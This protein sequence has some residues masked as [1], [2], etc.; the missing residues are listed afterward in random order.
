MSFKR[1]DINAPIYGVNRDFDLSRPIYD[2][3]IDDDEL[4]SDFGD[5][6]HRLKDSK[7]DFRPTF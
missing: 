2:R 1:D 4:L 5:G 3:H 6:G 7:E